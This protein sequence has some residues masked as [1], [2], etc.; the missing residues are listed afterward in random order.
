MLLSRFAARASATVHQLRKLD[1][2]LAYIETLP[3]GLFELPRGG[4]PGLRA[5][6]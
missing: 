3:R 4:T 5:V 6:G 1:E 2:T